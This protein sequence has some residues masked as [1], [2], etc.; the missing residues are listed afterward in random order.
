MKRSTSESKRLQSQNSR[1][2]QAGITAEPF[3]IGHIRYINILKWLRGLRVKIVNFLSFFCL[4]IP[5]RDLDTKKTT[6]N[7][8]V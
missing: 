3:Q 5:K 7:I 1:L 6:P 2:S 8:E 4:L